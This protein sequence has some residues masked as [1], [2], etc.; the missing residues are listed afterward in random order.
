M[1]FLGKIEVRNFRNSVRVLNVMFFFDVVL[2]LRFV[3]QC[4][5]RPRGQSEMQLL[6]FGLGWKGVSMIG[7]L[8][9]VSFF[10]FDV[11]MLVSLYLLR[12]NGVR[13]EDCAVG[14]CTRIQIAGNKNEEKK[15]KHFE[16][17]QKLHIYMV[18]HSAHRTANTWTERRN[19]LSVE[20]RSKTHKMHS[21]MNTYM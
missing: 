7:K 17:R 9:V 1:C 3:Y 10:F 13:V 12:F 16:K 11:R 14:I 5:L 18:I 15:K 4:A 2:E 21:Y 8:N 19:V 6:R 20:P